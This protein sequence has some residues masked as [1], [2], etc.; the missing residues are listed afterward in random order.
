MARKP[1]F[2]STS[3]KDKAAAK[4]Q[5]AEIADAMAP[6]MNQGPTTSEDLAT[7]LQRLGELHAAGVLTDQEY[8][9]K[10]AEIL[11]RM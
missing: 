10:K 5:A 4:R 2:W 1:G 8:A 7:T 6:L 11:A 9:A 3:F